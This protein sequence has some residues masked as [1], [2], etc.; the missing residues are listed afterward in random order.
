MKQLEG[1]MH[2]NNLFDPFQ[3]AYRAQHA[4]ET[5]ILKINNDILNGLD[6]DRCTVLASLDLSA[7]FDTVD[8][9][10]FLRRL[11]NEYGVEQWALQWFT[12]YLTDRTHQVS[13]N[14]TLSEPK[15]LRCGVPQ[16]SVLSARL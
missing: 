2:N 6:R 7:A 13:I 5:A 4:T 9:A 12:S 1:F 14:N 10:L 8:Y 15:S 11:Q 3:S 16:G